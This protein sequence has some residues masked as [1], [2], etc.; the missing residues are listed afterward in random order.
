MSSFII[1]GTLSCNIY[2]I[3]DDFFLKLVVFIDLMQ[4][5]VSNRRSRRWL[6]DRI[7]MELV[8]R[9]DAQEIRGLFAP[10]PWGNNNNLTFIS[11]IT[12]F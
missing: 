9:L 1:F 10:P 4:Q 2:W 12:Q 3:K 11:K 6:N 8:P 5:Q 7:L